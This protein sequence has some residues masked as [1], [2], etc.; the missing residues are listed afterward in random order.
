VSGTIAS[1][2][3][4]SWTITKRDG[5]TETV[6]ITPSTQFGT[7]NH[8]QTQTDFTVGEIIRVEGQASGNTVTATRITQAREHSQ[9]PSATGTPAP[10]SN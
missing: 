3:A 2:N 6:T 10:T 1:E 5:S 8:P 4:G 9:Q 7:K